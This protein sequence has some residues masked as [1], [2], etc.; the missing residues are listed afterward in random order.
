MCVRLG[1][2]LGGGGVVVSLCLSV[3]FDEFEE[4]GFLLVEFDEL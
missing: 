2:V 1:V 4:V 3:V